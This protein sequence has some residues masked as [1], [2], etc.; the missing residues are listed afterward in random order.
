MQHST[1]IMRYSFIAKFVFEKK[2]NK[3]KRGRCWSTYSKTM[4]YVHSIVMF[5]LGM[6]AKHS[7]KAILSFS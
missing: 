3:R 4:M 6:Y 7:S 2:E 1:A 5:H